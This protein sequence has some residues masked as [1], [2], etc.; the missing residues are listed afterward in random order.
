[1]LNRDCSE[2]GIRREIATGSGVG[3]KIEEQLKMTGAWRHNRSRRL[4]EPERHQF[5]GLLHRKR[6]WQNLGITRAGKSQL[7]VETEIWERA[8]LIMSRMLED[9]S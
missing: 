1:M 3:Q 5:Q 7:A 4:R 8:V 9:K 6:T 2:M